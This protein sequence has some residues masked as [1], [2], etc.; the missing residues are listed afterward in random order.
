MRV[1]PSWNRRLTLAFI[2]SVLAC[3]SVSEAR[4]FDF[5]LE[6]VATY[7]RG[8]LGTSLVKDN[9]Y[10]SSSGAGT[11]F[12]KEVG[13]NASGEFGFLIAGDRLIFRAGAELLI[14]RHFADIKGTNADGT[15]LFMLDSQIYSL[16]A[17]ANFE[18][19]AYKGQRTRVLI[20]VGG[21]VGFV[22]LDNNY[23][24]TS[25][26]TASLG[27][28]DFTE[29]GEARAAVLQGYIGYEFLFTDTVTAVLDAGYRH[30][31]VRSIQSAKDV[32]A[33]AGSQGEGDDL[34]NTDG[35][36]RNFDLSGPFAGFSLRFYLDL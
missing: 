32:V 26:G 5:R 9:A 15:E 2:V 23:K 17:I 31:P 34:Q 14:P 29:S 4:K 22:T 21:G 25:D 18:F 33:I 8:T 12:D 35:S 24:M 11:K 30:M 10:G 16:N 28:A 1:V 7:F 27:V 3:P 20:G 36:L 13:S 19:M 6:S